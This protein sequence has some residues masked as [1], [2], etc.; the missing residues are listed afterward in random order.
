MSIVIN[1]EDNE[2]FLS[3]FA[4]TIGS[5]VEHGRVNIPEKYGSGYVMGFLFGKQLRMVVRNYVL[6]E[7]V[8]ISRHPDWLS[9]NM[10][11]ISLNNI[12]KPSWKEQDDG[13]AVRQQPPSVTITTN[14][15]EPE[16]H[17]RRHQGFNDIHL[18]VDAVYL[19]ELLN[20]ETDHHILRNII[21]NDQ[22]LIFEQVVSVALQDTAAEIAEALITPPLHH[23]FYKLKAQELI[24]YLLMELSQRKDHN[25]QALNSRDIGM[26]YEVK[27]RI[28]RDLSQVP[29]L[30][31]LA[32][33]AGMSESKLKR[34]FKQVF[35]TNIYAYYQSLRM[36]EAA[37]LLKHKQMSVSEAGYALGFVNLSHFTRVFEGY[38]GV[39]PK[40]Y[41]TGR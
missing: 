26:L 36:H 16:L 28:E 39:K 31:E 7:E 29:V 35:G 32:K 33:F 30:P 13:S 2:G 41:S 21:A 24:C 3:S 20:T 1:P 23:F 18:G 38:I 15:F 25:V 6:Q 27:Y 9:P 17:L 40:K 37:F 5:S 34:L 19:R 10:I 11:R 14:G 4:K 8:V 12:L 22:P